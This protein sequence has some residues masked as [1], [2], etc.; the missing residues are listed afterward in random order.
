MRVQLR[1]ILPECMAVVCDPKPD[2]AAAYPEYETQDMI[3][4][5]DDASVETEVFCQSSGDDTESDPDALLSFND[6]RVGEIVEVWWEG[7]KQWFE[8]EITSL[9]NRRK[10]FEV[11][12]PC[13][14]KKL[15]HR[16][17]DYPVRYPE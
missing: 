11:F 15:L 6:L 17:S 13:D 9:E 8:G 5:D 3:P 14:G 12:Y 10:M 7:E 4:I 2:A 16:S 1:E